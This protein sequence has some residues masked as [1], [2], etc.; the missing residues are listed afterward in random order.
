M[1]WAICSE[2]IVID[3][4]GLG[5]PFERKMWSVQTAWAIRLKT[6]VVHS[7]SSGYP[8][9]KEIGD[10]LSNWS[11]IQTQIS[12]KFQSQNHFVA[13][14]SLALNQSVILQVMYAAK[15]V[16]KRILYEIVTDLCSFVA[17]FAFI[18][19]IDYRQ[20]IDIRFV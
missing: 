8:F 13:S 15:F 18:L 7:S 6:I 19:S 11:Y 2:K 10:C 3:L 4:N 16:Y 12:A 5:Y 14:H 20:Y 1:A 17:I 9:K